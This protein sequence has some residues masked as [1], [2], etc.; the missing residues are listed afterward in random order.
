MR[1]PFYEGEIGEPIPST[2]PEGMAAGVHEITSAY[3]RGAAQITNSM[4]EILQVDSDNQRNA[5]TAEAARLKSEWSISYV[6]ARDANHG[7]A[8]ISRDPDALRKANDT[9]LQETYK[10]FKDKAS[11]QRVKDRFDVATSH[12]YGVY[13]IENSNN[14][15]KM[16]D[17]KSRS[18]LAVSVRMNRAR[19]EKVGPEEAQNV[20]GDMYSAAYSM[21]LLGALPYGGARE[22]VAKEAN[23]Y[24]NWLSEKDMNS[25]RDTWQTRYSAGYYD[26]ITLPG[27]GPGGTDLTISGVKPDHLRKMSSEILHMDASQAEAQERAKKNHLNSVF[28]SYL[29]G[30]IGWTDVMAER[31]RLESN[32]IYFGKEFSEAFE[33]TRIRKSQPEKA[34]DFLAEMQFMDE[35]N[36]HNGVPPGDFLNRVISAATPTVNSP[37][38]LSPETAKRIVN[39]YM[40]AGDYWNGDG[41][42]QARQEIEL[43]TPG[44]S[45]SAGAVIDPN[46]AKE[47]D[48]ARYWM[49]KALYNVW[50]QSPM[51]K[52]YSA[53]ASA[54]IY[55]YKTAPI[56]ERVRSAPN[57][58]TP[59]DMNLPKEQ[60]INKVIDYLNADEAYK[61]AQNY[62]PDK[63]YSKYTRW[64][65]LEA[66]GYVYDPFQGKYVPQ[67]NVRGLDFGKQGAGKK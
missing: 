31:R 66:I 39:D 43:A 41:W 23:D 47:N 40:K 42:R 37:A 52:D 3:A 33:Q 7:N 9:A 17:E 22:I 57:P 28:T 12:E 8:E 46:M 61:K 25:N 29:F 55:H 53:A 60:L 20:F 64:K 15:R 63:G 10:I 49:M 65:M 34:D 14:W 26:S 51:L 38:K 62:N 11:N 18:D 24:M 59:A 4:K 2:P 16:K 5:D 21:E 30:D 32:G 48:Q 19:L 27:L 13:G 44:T 54:I 58:L 67:E 6:S 45:S 56:V 36:R 1:I 35:L 50:K